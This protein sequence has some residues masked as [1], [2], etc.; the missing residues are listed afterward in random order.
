MIQEYL[1]E[2][3]I[4]A[5]VKVVGQLCEDQCSRGPNL[6]VNGVMHHAVGAAGLRALLDRIFGDGGCS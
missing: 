6:I 4:S 5:Q 2:R 3:A 1:A